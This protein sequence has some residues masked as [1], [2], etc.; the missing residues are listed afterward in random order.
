M[1]FK[2]KFELFMKDFKI[3]E[4]NTGIS[5]IND[6]KIIVTSQKNCCLKGDINSVIVNGVTV[7]VR[8]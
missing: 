6:V 1:S 3:E 8:E 4:I 5:F 2:E 7:Y